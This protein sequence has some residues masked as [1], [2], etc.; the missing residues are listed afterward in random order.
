MERCDFASICAVIR[1]YLLAGAFDSQMD[2]VETLFDSYLQ[3]THEVF[4]NG[5]LNKWLNGILRLSPDIREFYQK[6][7]S[8]GE[9]AITLLDAIIPFL[10]DS[11]M[12]V[13]EV[14]DLLTH[15][16][17]VSRERKKELCKGYPC[18]TAAQKAAFL[19]KVLD[20]GVIRD[21]SPATFA[22]RSF[23]RP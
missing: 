15:D 23:F 5:Q 18:H 9:L 12:V 7:E 14:H 8:C 17:T 19:A 11:G 3:E 22:S 2:F 1:R 6:E 13:M 10:S 4:D 21:S 16:T 20:Y